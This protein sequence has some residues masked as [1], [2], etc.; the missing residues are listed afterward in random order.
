MIFVNQY[1]KSIASLMTEILEER[2]KN[3][4]FRHFKT[5]ND[6]LYEK[7]IGRIIC[8]YKILNLKG[9]LGC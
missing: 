7:G 1:R 9:H 4:F 8:A 5:D 3:I 6:N 2:N